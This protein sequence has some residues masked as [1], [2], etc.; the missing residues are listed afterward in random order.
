MLGPLTVAASYGRGRQQFP[1]L[2][3]HRVNDEQ[4]PFFPSLPTAVF[5]ERMKHIAEQY[6]VLTV[7]DL[8]DR[9]RRRNVPRRALAVTFDDGYRDSLTHAAPVLARYGLPATIFLTTGYI[10]TPEMPWYDVLALAFKTT[11]QGAVELVPGQVLPLDST[12]QRLQSLQVALRHFKQIGDEERRRALD[13]LADT[14]QPACAQRQKRVMLSWEEADTLR[15]LG[16]SVGAHTVSHPI[17]SRV[18]PEE[19]WQEIQGSKIAIERTLGCTVRVFAYP[20][21]GSRDYTGTTVELVRRAGFSC[22][23]TTRR[24]LNAF[25]TPAFELRRGGPSEQH[26]P[27]YALK[28]AYY[29]LAGA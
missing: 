3:F 19:A 12:T 14:L 22:A 17:L 21:G 25:S 27:T 16:F 20:N 9:V 11:A 28:L 7:E 4:D 13:R 6:V 2:V 23:V 29:H 1:V 8:A 18:G 24:G 5:A 26:L 15:G 10:G